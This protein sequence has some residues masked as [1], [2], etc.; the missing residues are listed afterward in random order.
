[1]YSAVG[2]S[3]VGEL[4][5]A[6][7]PFMLVWPGL[8]HADACRPGLMDTC[9]ASV[10]MVMLDW[11]GKPSRGP[12]IAAGAVQLQRCL[13]LCGQCRAL[14]QGHGQE[15]VALD[16]HSRVC[17]PFCWLSPSVLDAVGRPTIGC[18]GRFFSPVARRARAEAALGRVA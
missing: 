4:D 18:E 13:I 15:A 2:W 14:V 11:S 16:V 7:T 10:G 8:L 1:M 3:K 9:V 6:R 12:T 17:T 5:A